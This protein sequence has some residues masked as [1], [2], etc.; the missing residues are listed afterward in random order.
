MHHP[1]PIYNAVRELVAADVL[2]DTRRRLLWAVC[3]TLPAPKLRFMDDQDRVLDVSRVS[4]SRNPT[5]IPSALIAYRLHPG[6]LPQFV[7]V[8][9]TGEEI[10]VSDRQDYLKTYLGSLDL[11]A[12][13]LTT[14]FKHDHARR[15]EYVQCY[16]D[17]GFERMLLYDNNDDPTSP[18]HSI[19]WPL[20]YWLKN[21]EGCHCAQALQLDRKSVV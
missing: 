20:P 1:S 21:K 9:S 6:P 19:H 16:T 3:P 8:I 11:N 18:D 17:L 4:S 2:L 10:C 13:V 7:T 5:E 12:T 15:G 14:L